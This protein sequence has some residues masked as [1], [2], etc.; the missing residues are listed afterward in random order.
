M[1]L[2]MEMDRM[3]LEMELL[4]LV[5]IQGLEVLPKVHP[6]L[7]IQC[8]EWDLFPFVEV[9]IGFSSRVELFPLPPVFPLRHHFCQTGLLNHRRSFLQGNLLMT[10]E[11]DVVHHIYP[12]EILVLHHLVVSL[13]LLVFFLFLVSLDLERLV[14]PFDVVLVQ[15]NLALDLVFF[16]VPCPASLVSLLVAHI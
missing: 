15:N 8:M 2:E 16:L 13:P 1:D 12:T 7:L 14:H 6:I 4:V 3:D 5:A 10:L 9:S 11:L